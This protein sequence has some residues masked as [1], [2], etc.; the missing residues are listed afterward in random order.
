MQINIPYVR[1]VTTGEDIIVCQIPD[2]RTVKE[3]QCT[4]RSRLEITGNDI[5]NILD[6]SKK[7]HEKRRVR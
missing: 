6:K 5:A 7:A 3:D 1:G 4:R 2:G